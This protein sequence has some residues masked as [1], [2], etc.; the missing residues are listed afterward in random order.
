MKNNTL[1]I[2][3]GDIDDDFDDVL[4]AWEGGQSATPLN[5]LSFE[6]MPGFLSY[7]TPK[8]WELLTALRKHGHLSIRKLAGLL[9][10]DYKNTHSDVKALI[11]V[12]LIEKDADGLV[13]VPWD[14]V[15]THLQLAA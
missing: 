6:S 13:F 11:E 9:K 14:N 10:R 7:L 4:K 8:R 3:I 5:Q 2:K 1:V 12:G 15:E